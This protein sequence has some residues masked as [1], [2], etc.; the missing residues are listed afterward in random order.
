MV[1][2]VNFSLGSRV[3]GH[4]AE[5]C[6]KDRNAPK[7]REVLSIL[8]KSIILLPDYENT[9]ELL[10]R[11][12]RMARRCRERGIVP[13]GARAMRAARDGEGTLSKVRTN[14]DGRSRFVQKR[15]AGSVKR[16]GEPVKSG[17][18][19]VK[20]GV[21]SVK[22]RGRGCFS[23]GRMKSEDSGCRALLFRV[24]RAPFCR[25]GGRRGRRPA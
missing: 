13:L 19:S 9:F 8:P 22:R 1:R 16:W 14:E 20:G 3:C 10:S 21:S 4:S 12:R 17:T 18:G 15:G 23:Q 24:A 5:R 11:R 6:F 7:T 2:A 25:G